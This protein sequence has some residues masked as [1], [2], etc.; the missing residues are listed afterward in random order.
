A[1]VQT[2]NV[3]LTETSAAFAWGAQTNG[4]AA[5]GVPTIFALN[6]LYPDTVANGGCPT[7][8]PARPAALR[9]SPTPPRAGAGPP[10]PPPLAVNRAQVA[11]AQRVGTAAS[12]VLLKWSSTNLVGT[13]GVPTA[14]ASVAAAAYRSCVAPCMTVFP[15]NANNTNSSPFVDYGND[16]LYVGDD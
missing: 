14:P 12:L 5:A 13:I 9:S 4:T 8:P 7:A 11:F 2:G 1:F 16:A 3:T 10:P 15:L 6:Q